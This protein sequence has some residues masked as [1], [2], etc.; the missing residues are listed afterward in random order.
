MGTQ[1]SFNRRWIQLAC[2]MAAAG[3]GCTSSANPMQPTTPLAEASGAT[4]VQRTVG[5]I[6]AVQPLL[7]PDLAAV[8]RATAQFHN[9]DVAAAAG[10][11]FGEPCVS[12]PA[13]IMGIHTPNQALIRSQVIDPERPEVLLYLEKPGG[14][15][16]L[17]GVEYLQTV[18]LRSPSG[19]VAPWFSAS[20]WPAD[21]VMVN[22]A[23][24]LFGQTFDGPMPGH[25]P[26]MPWHWDFHVWIWAHNPSGTFAQWNPALSCN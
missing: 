17:I 3:A 19:Q 4:P 5:V 10:Y 11:V 16:R 6:D 26:S 22:S 25:N 8:R 1:K 18:L 14:G 21:Y 2:L 9:A 23:P 15:M 24:Q 12:S 20:P 13:G 7:G